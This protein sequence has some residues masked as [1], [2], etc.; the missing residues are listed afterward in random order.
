MT[1]PTNPRDAVETRTGQ[2]VD[3]SLLDEK[4]TMV[5]GIF[6]QIARRY[7][8]FNAVSSLGIYRRWLRRVARL[9]ACTPDERVIDVAG[10][11]G[12]VAFELCRSCPPASIELTDFTPEMLEVAKDRIAAGANC[13][14]PVTVAEADAMHL[15]YADG[16][17]DVLTMAYGLRNFS[18]RLLAMREAS[19][20]L[21][22]G[23]RAVILEF[24]TPPNPA[25]RAV[26]NVYL[27][28]VVPAVGGV[29][30]G[31]RSGFKYLA[32]SIRAFP[33][34]EVVARELGDSGFAHV[35]YHDC[36]GGIAAVYLARK[37]R[38]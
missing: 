27:G 11:T 31:D 35:E 14:V 25:W 16:S 37:D 9:A 26:Y 6:S 21:V 38:R 20:V 23:G 33:R 4:G 34:Q 2:A 1:V 18:D 19:R 22:P 36:T 13:G 30:A 29:V 8:A 7:D 12:D 5:R 15:P 17:F 24:G 28:H 32:S 3:E 10:G